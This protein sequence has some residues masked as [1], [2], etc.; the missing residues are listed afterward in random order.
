[1]SSRESIYL[2]NQ[3]GKGT[4]LVRKKYMSVIMLLSMV[5]LAACSSEEENETESSDVYVNKEGIPIVDER[6]NVTMMTPGTGIEEWEDMEVLQDYAEKTN[7]HF[8]FDTPP[9]DDFGTNL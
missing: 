3:F 9:V 4:W 8:E 2:Q 7:I 6:I 1:M 5:K